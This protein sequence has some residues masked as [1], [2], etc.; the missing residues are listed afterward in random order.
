MVLVLNFVSQFVELNIGATNSLMPKLNLLGLISVLVLNYL[1]FKPWLLRHNFGIST[2]LSHVHTNVLHFCFIFT[3]KFFT[4]VSCSHQ[5][6]SLLFHVHTKVL[7]FCFMFTPKFFT[8]VS[9]SH[10]S[11]LHLNSASVLNYLMFTLT[12]FTFVS[13]SHQSYLH[14]NSLS[15]VNAKF[16]YI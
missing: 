2:K 14:L 13:C 15:H 4:F 3:P 8:F 12:F 5:S 16:I 9:C 7:H 6:S 1:T 11:Y 10:Q